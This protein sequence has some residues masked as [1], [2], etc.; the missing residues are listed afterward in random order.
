MYLSQCQNVQE[1][2]IAIHFLHSRIL[3]KRR[4]KYI[5]LFKISSTNNSIA[6]T[7]FKEISKG[8]WPC[9]MKIVIGMYRLHRFHA[10]TYNISTK[11]RDFIIFFKDGIK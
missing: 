10:K 6:L 9:N 3:C 5:N 1:V 8:L 7:T 2:S 4:C 11:W